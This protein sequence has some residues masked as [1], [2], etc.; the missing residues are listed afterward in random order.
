M[1][2]DPFPQSRDTESKSSGGR[3]PSQETWREPPR[4]LAPALSALALALF[5]L[6]GIGLVSQLLPLRLLAPAWQ[7]RFAN[8]LIERAPLALIGLGLLQLA[9]HLDPSA[10]HLQARWQRL[11]RLGVIAAL[12]FL[13]LLPVQVM[14]TARSMHGMNGA[15]RSQQQRVERNLNLLRQEIRASSSLG[16]L[17]RR[18]RDIQAP[19]LILDADS[20]SKPLP[21]LKQSLL[22]SVDQSE[23]QLRRRFAGGGGGRSWALVERSGRG[24][25]ASLVLAFAFAAC[26]PQWGDAD[27][28]VLMGWQNRWRRLRRRG[29]AARKTLSHED[30]LRQ[31]SKKD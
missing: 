22:A 29:P 14:A 23:R 16:D 15:Q 4:M 9:P 20:L 10:R 6:F 5:L 11:G 12:G 28:S 7:L 30:Y 27:V 3:R 21:K 17:Q 8:A 25:L 19:D 26:T 13:L 24:I 2:Q 31:L 1:S 18:I